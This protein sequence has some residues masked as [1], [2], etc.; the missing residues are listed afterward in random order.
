MNSSG[1]RELVTKFAQW[2]SL[3]ALIGVIAGAA[4]ALFL[5]LLEQVTAARLA[6]ERFVYALPVV[7]LMLGLLWERYGAPIKAGNNLIIDT[8]HDGGP[9]VPLRM[10]PM[11]L[12][13]TVSAHL[14]GASVGREGTAVQMGASLADW[15]AHRL[16]V[17]DDVRRHLLAAGVAGGFG[18]VFGTPIAGALFA[19]EFV[20]VGQLQVRAL[21]PAVVAAFVGDLTTR[22]L[23]VEHT[24]YPAPPS[25]P[26]T[27]GLFG[28]WLV[29]AAVVAAVTIAFIELTHF[30]KKQGE[31]HVPR[32]PARMVL[33][34][35]VLVVLWKLVGTSDFLGLGVTTIVRAFSEPALPASSFA[36]KL[37]FTAISLSAGFPGGEVT[38]LFFIGA[39]L[40][41]ACAAS[42]GV[43][44][45]LAAGV[46]LAAVFAAASN[47]PIALS[48]M[49]IEL[50][51][52]NVFPHVALVAVVA[53]LLTGA[54]GIYPSQ[55]MKRLKHGRALER[56][57]TLQEHRAQRP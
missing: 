22:T 30:L 18:S 1:V 15:V 27:P 10:A 19:L 34:G 52:P 8:L 45:E 14:V 36:W 9:P 47:A 41:S 54:R 38:P 5:T 48:L 29:F 4:S 40:G 12:L 42:L 57:T 44:V 16:R 49:A 33:G 25:V 35:V 50:L 39:A 32:L 23:G 46:G 26:L 13:G 21:V 31:L 37:L 17:K 43:P 11:V 56:V 3:G 20:V 24:S 7:G 55:R 2:L 28:G 51:G 53:F 6:N